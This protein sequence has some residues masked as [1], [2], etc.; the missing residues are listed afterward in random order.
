YAHLGLLQNAGDFRL[1]GD[2][3]FSLKKIGTIQAEVV[4]QLYAPTLIQH[5]FFNTQR[6]VWENHFD[7]TLESSLAGTYALP[8]FDFSVSVR[9]TL[10]TNYIYFDTLAR[11]RQENA[12][13]NLL[14]LTLQ[15]D[16]RLGPV[17]FN[18][19]LVFQ[20][21]SSSVLRVPDL[22]TK[23]SLYVEGKIFRKAML[24]RLGI[25][26]RLTTPYRADLYDPVSGQFHLQNQYELPF[27]PLVDVFFSFKVR[28]FRF[29]LKVEN[30]LTPVTRSYY[31]QVPTYALPFGWSNGGLRFGLSWRLVD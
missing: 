7:K 24:A 16:F 13:I 29:F 31:Y 28:T 23:H 10:I 14:Q 8:A 15:K 3:T 4:N 1:S 5:R 21:S 17:R 27:T 30:I 12:V 26:A 22:Y 20:N 11:P 25:D 2:L 6:L 9:N 19:L 18:N